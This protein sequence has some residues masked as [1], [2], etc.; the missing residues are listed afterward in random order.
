MLPAVLRKKLEEETKRLLWPYCV[1]ACACQYGCTD[2]EKKEMQEMFMANDRNEK[3]IKELMSDTFVSQ[4]N[5]ITSGKDTQVLKEE[6]PYLFSLVGMKEHFKLLTGVQINE[7]FEQVMTN[8]FSIV[9]DYFQSL[10]IEK[11]VMA[12]KD[13][14]EIQASGGPSGAVLM[15]L[16]HFK[17]EHTKMFHIVDKTCIADEVETER[18]PPT[19]CIVVCGKCIFKINPE[20]GSKV[21]RLEK[22]RSNA[23]NPKVLTLITRISEFEWRS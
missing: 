12:G 15:L 7:A 13:R 18:L 14:A 2:E 22:K 3:R 21:E 11:S 6:W 8:K 5:D 16:S 4:R 19:P 20:K 17:E 10:P 9:L 23:V 1:G